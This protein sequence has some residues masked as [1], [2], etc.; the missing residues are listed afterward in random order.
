MT[1]FAA[2]EIMAHAYDY[3]DT[4]NSPTV[5]PRNSVLNVATYGYA[6]FTNSP[7]LASRNPDVNNGSDFIN[8][9]NT[10][11]QVA[12]ENQSCPVPGV[13]SG[14]EA[15]IA[16][17]QY[18]DSHMYAGLSDGFVNGFWKGFERTRSSVANDCK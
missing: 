10:G 6:D 18:A 5:I 9:E 17:N 8:G 16:K 2:T 11:A 12:F 14:Q 7:A 4:T 1:L 3:T 13:R 15:D